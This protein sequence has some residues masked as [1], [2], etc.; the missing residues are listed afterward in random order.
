MVGHDV[1]DLG[2]GQVVVA[3]KVSVKIPA[4][5]DNG[6]RLRLTNEGEPGRQGGPP[7]DLYVFIYVESHDFFERNDTDVVCQVTISFIQAALGE[8][9]DGRTTL[10]VAH[11][12]STIRA[13]SRRGPTRKW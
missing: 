12:L 1:G 13:A 7:G 11:R 6:S 8:L 10:A 4:G 3:K 2:A 9:V 5:V